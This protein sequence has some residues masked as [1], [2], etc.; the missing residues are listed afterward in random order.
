MKKIDRAFTGT[1]ASRKGVLGLTYAVGREIDP[2][3]YYRYRVRAA[4]VGQAARRSLDTGR[5]WRV[6]DF[7]SADGATLLEMAPY[8]PAGS[9]IV[10]LEYSADLVSRAGELGRGI[11]VLQGDIAD[12]P[13]SVKDRPYD[14][15]TALAVL[16]HLAEP[17][18]ALREAASVLT[19]N[20]ILIATFPEPFWDRLSTRLGLLEDHH[21]V[22]LSR[23]RIS[24]WV[25]QAGLEI[26]EYQRF[27]FAPLG[28]LPYLRIPV[29]PTFSLALDKIIRRLW[30]FN[31]LFVNQL[32]VARKAPPSRA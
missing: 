3:L 12:L 2:A 10:G 8:L 20:G 26:L 32:L 21:E 4:V 7:G 13:D 30:L 17:L 15:V 27:M 24:S 5:P 31:W 16:E 23:G 11:R 14:L 19:E 6:L 1:E 18:V 22:H 25:G 29:S 9:E 28:F